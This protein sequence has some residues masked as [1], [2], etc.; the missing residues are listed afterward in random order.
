MFDILYTSCLRG[1]KKGGWG[2]AGFG[3]QGEHKSWKLPLCW[4]EE[5]ASAVR[6]TSVSRHYGDLIKRSP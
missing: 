2:R 6:E 1:V 3:G 5:N 4:L